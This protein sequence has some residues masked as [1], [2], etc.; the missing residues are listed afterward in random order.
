MAGVSLSF[1]VHCL[2]GPGQGEQKGELLTDIC[3]VYPL[4]VQVGPVDQVSLEP[5]RDKRVER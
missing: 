4:Q 2:C 1:V 5:S 3:Q